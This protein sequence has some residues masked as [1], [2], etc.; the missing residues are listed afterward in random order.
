MSRHWH[1]VHAH[2]IHQTTRAT[3]QDNYRKIARRR[4]ELSGFADPGAALAFLHGRD[5]DGGRKNALL[6]ALVAEAQAGES[7]TA[8][9]AASLVILALWPGLDALRK[10]LLRGFSEGPDVLA[11][12][13]TGRLSQAIATADLD[14]V[15]WIA[16]TFLRNIERDLKREYI[17]QAG[18]TCD[19]RIEAYAEIAEWPAHPGWDV[20]STLRSHIGSDAELVMAVVILGFT[21]KEAAHA[22][23]LSYEAARKRYQRAI[24]RLSG[25]IDPADG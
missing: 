25:K 20:L 3:Y 1:E 23:G 21:Q 14:R 5:R 15:T 11:G 19:A 9:T 18:E 17:R 24:F 16:A 12:E 22:L 6:R 7:D 4:P 2:L 10:R 8:D 13:L